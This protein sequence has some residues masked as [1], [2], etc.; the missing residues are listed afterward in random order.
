LIEALKLAERM[1]VK[2]LHVLS[3]SQRMV[4]Q[5]AGQ[6]QV[7][8]VDILQRVKEVQQLRK[9][10]ESFKINYIARE[11]NDLADALSTASLPKKVKSG[12]GKMRESD[13]FMG[14]LDENPDEGGTE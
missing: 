9:N 6:Y 1:G 14:R 13:D 12:G 11:G 4:R 5:V 8:N 7:K 3:D 10:F 2:S